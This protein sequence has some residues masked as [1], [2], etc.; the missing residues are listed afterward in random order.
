MLAIA[1]GACA[2][3]PAGGVPESLMAEGLESVSARRFDSVQVRP[4]T[5]FSPYNAVMLAEPI[6]EYSDPDPARQEVPL[7]QTRKAEFADYIAELFSSELASMVSPELVTESGPGVIELAVSLVDITATVPPRSA[8][9]AG[10]VSIALRAVGDVTL[11]IDLSDSESGELLARVVDRKAVDGVAIAKQG[12]LVTR[13]EDVE[14]IAK[15]WARLTRQGLET[16]SA[17]R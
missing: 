12:E 15:R 8:G 7:D 9:P 6:I 13:W 2:T 16:A 3:P 17:S 1:L 11:V 5:D 10:R 4:D 14:A